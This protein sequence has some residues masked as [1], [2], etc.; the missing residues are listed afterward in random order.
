MTSVSAGLNTDAS[1]PVFWAEFRRQM[2][3]ARRWAY[4][5]HAAVAP[6]TGGAKMVINHWAEDATCN[7]SA[8]Y[9]AWIEQIEELRNLAA[10]MI[11]A[12]SSEI[13]LVGNTTAGINLVAEGFPW[14]PGDNIVTRADEFPSNQYPWLNLAPKGVEMRRIPTEGGRLDLQRLADACDRRTRIVS[15]SWVTYSHGWRHDLRQ[16]AEIVHQ[17]GA[18]LFIDAIQGLGAF[19]LDVKKIPVDFLAADGHKWMLGPEGAGLFYIRREHLNLLRPT[20]V[21]WSSVKHSHDFN[22][23]E[24]DLK[25]TAARYEG[26]SQNVCG[27]TALGASLILLAQFPAEAI[28]ARVLEITDLACRRLEE[29]GALIISD[30]GSKENKSGIVLFELPGRDPMAL[31]RECFEK[32]VIL[33]CRSGRLRISPHAYN[34]EADVDR[35]IAALV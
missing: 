16:L 14:Q 35:L 29:L 25:D 33:S 12:D 9:P 10:Q 8:F 15:I 17:R 34:D 2:P 26:G 6:L 5:D 23:I 31:R 13:A 32:G 3:I 27:L 22:R 4:F 11:G 18:L 7:G 28:A 24:L 1:K 21:G 19:P 20:G 30:R